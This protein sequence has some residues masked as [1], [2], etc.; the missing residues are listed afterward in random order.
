MKIELSLLNSYYINHDES[1]IKINGEQYNILCTCNNKHTRLWIQKNKSQEAF[2]KIGFLPTFKRIIVKDGTE[3]Y[4]PF[5]IGLAQCLSH[6]L[7]YLVDYYTKIPTQR[8]APKKL[9]EFLSNYNTRRNELIKQNIKHFS[10]E[11]Y[12]QL[13][14]EYDSI[15][16]KWEQEIRNDLNNPLLAEETCLWTRMKYDNKKMNEKS[17]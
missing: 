8:K 15:I 11:E 17:S 9:S 16:N 14:N 10:N 6:I 4:N 7:R 5:E 2:K 1:Q 12:N 13:I 3:L